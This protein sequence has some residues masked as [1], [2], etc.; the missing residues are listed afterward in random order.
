MHFQR[1]E[2]LKHLSSDERKVMD[3]SLRRMK[4][5]G[6]LETDPEV[7]GGYRFPNLLHMLYFWMESQRTSD[8][9][10]PGPR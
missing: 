8:E 7:K 3:N 4:R 1:S 10:T 9:V 6:A 2:L 5:F